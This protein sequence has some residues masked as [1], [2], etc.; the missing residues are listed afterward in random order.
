MLAAVD[1]VHQR[2]RQDVRVGV[3]RPVERQAAGA[4]TARAAARETPSSAL[5]PSRRLVGRPVE[6]A[7]RVVEL[8]LRGDRPADE[9][10]GDLAGDR[11]D[12]RA[13]RRTRRS[14]CRRRGS[15]P[16]RARRSSGRTG[17]RRGRAPARSGRR[18]TSTSTWTVGRP[19]QSRT[20][21]ARIALM[22]GVCM[23]VSPSRVRSH[24]PS[25]A[26][27]NCQHSDCQQS[28]HRSLCGSDD[29]GAVSRSGRPR[30]GRTARCADR[31]RPAWSPATS[32]PCC[33]TGS[34][35]SPG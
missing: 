2:H 18:S 12:G 23:G 30:P 27:L 24:R 32:A 16:P 11:G 29:A 31:H 19:R 14:G 25:A 3:Q 6:R 35:G 15:R 28:N 10:L 26:N 34:A 9:R 17:R 13:E 20:S 21:R 22:R 1:Q 33:G 5:A 8:A 4:A 7:Q